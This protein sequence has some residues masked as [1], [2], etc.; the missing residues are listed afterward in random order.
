MTILLTMYSF[1]ILMW[2]I[3]LGI[4]YTGTYSRK[5]RQRFARLFFCSPVWPVILLAWA[6]K[7][8]VGLYRVAFIEKV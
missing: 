8:L 5:E 6:W 7:E 3:I 4:F 2:A 1:G